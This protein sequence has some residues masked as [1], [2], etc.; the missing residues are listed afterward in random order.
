MIEDFLHLPPLSTT[1]VV[2]LELRISPRIFEKNRNDPNGILRGLGETD[3]WKNQKS[4]KSRDTVPLSHCWKKN[5]IILNRVGLS[6]LFGHRL[7]CWA[8]KGEEDQPTCFWHIYQDLG[9]L[10][11][12]NEPLWAL[13]DS[14]FPGTKNTFTEDHNFFCHNGCLLSLSVW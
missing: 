2:H 5:N 1:P 3:S 8:G 10:N 9:D 12:S 4:K 14:L 11:G 6:L 13:S 7:E